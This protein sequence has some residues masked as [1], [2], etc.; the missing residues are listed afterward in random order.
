MLRV[1]GQ[2][3]L[4]GSDQ[5]IQKSAKLFG[6]IGKEE[7]RFPVL[8]ALMPPVHKSLV[9][10]SQGSGKLALS[11]QSFFD[12][13]KFSFGESGRIHLSGPGGKIVGFVHQKEVIALCFKKAL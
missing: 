7:N 11:A 2:P 3:V 10:L 8:L 6:R 9:D 13:E 4:K 5:T 12:L 1:L